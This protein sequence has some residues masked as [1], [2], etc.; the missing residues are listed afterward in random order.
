MVESS[1]L[2][3]RKQQRKY[4][5]CFSMFKF[6]RKGN[7]IIIGFSQQTTKVKC[8]YPAFEN[9]KLISKIGQEWSES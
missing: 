5:S 1:Y 2:E 6:L 7:N 9:L 3:A 4:S 8:I